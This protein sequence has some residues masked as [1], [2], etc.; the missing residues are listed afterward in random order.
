MQHYKD[1]SLSPSMINLKR[2]QSNSIELLDNNTADVFSTKLNDS[3]ISTNAWK[4][5]NTHY[6]PSF[7]NRSPH[8]HHH[9]HHYHHHHHHHHHHHR[10]QTHV[11]LST[12]IN[13]FERKR[14]L[15]CLLQR[16]I[17]EGN[18]IK[19][20]VHRL[21]SQRF[22]H[23]FKLQQQ[24]QNVVHTPSTPTIKI[25]NQTLSILNSRSTP[26]ASV[27]INIPQQSSNSP[28]QITSSPNRGISWLL[29]SSVFSMSTTSTTNCSSGNGSPLR[30]CCFSNTQDRTPMV[31]G[32]HD[33]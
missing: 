29:S 13:N 15:P 24:K 7:S 11:N 31:I 21:K 28:A 33:R 14:R 20:A 10:H 30:T 2:L 5:T 25:S 26:S 8:H 9:H 3:S 6:K 1:T 32:I 12:K 4:S 18:L 23:T 27:N 16:L 19:E 17:D 22:S